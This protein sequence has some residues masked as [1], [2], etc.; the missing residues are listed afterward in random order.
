MSKEYE[1]H[2]THQ[3][4]ATLAYRK[5]LERGRQDGRAIDDWLE[6]E[7]ELHRGRALAGVAIGLYLNPSS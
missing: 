2:L 1:P 5:F 7:R 6:A 3:E 4:I